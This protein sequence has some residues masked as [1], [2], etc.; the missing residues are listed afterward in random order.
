VVLRTLE[1]VGSVWPAA[2]AGT[3]LAVVGAGLGWATAGTVSFGP[4]RWVG[5]WVRRVVRPIVRSRSWRRRA[6][7]IFANNATTLAV[8][9]ALGRWHVTALVG[10]ASVGVSLGIGL[11]LLSREP[12]Y[13]PDG[14]ERADGSGR[15]AVRV[16]VAL[17]LIEPLAIMLA[18]GLALGRVTAGFA[19]SEVWA[20]F[21]LWVLP[22]TLLAAAGE[23]MWLG[24]VFHP[25]HK[26][27]GET[28]E[29]A[30]PRAGD[31]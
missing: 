25:G 6:A 11:R 23:A 21:A 8:I 31:P 4:V 18:I 24:V 14:L 5:W 30:D 13:E 29:T 16:G 15:W 17:N 20:T 7:A 1:V 12:D 2:L 28:D 9:V 3:G 22:A 27:G 19:G 10:V 26:P